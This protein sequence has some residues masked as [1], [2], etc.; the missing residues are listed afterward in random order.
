MADDPPKRPVPQP[1]KTLPERRQ[2]RFRDHD[3]A[4]FAVALKVVTPILGGSFFTAGDSIGY[5]RHDPI[6]VPTIRG[7][8]RFW[9]RALQPAWLSEAELR[10]RERDLWGGMGAGGTENASEPKASR[11]CVRVESVNPAEPPLDDSP[12]PMNGTGYALFPAREQKQG[13]Q[14]TRPVIPRLEPGI[15]FTLRI[16]CPHD[17]LQ[18]VRKAVQAWILFGGYGSRTRRGLGSLTVTADAALWLPSL[19]EDLKPILDGVGSTGQT[20]SLAGSALYVGTPI[21]AA[22]N[23]WDHAVGQLQ[24]FRQQRGFAREQGTQRP[25]RSRWPEPDKIRHLTG[26]TR[27]HMPRPEFKND[28]AWPRAAFGLPIVG[29]FNGAN[30]PGPFEITWQATGAAKPADRLASPLI[31]KALPLADGRFLPC[32][33]WLSRG[34]PDGMVVLTMNRTVVAKSPAP[35][36]KMRGNNDK[37]VHEALVDKA[38]VREAFL[39]WLV[40]GCNWKRVSG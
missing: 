28:P 21:A 26:Q 38:S 31:V 34:F 7:H 29:R 20:P 11:V 10:S 17:H 35:F 30:E 33:L 22:D 15:T 24:W 36:G 19:A 23:A 6:R 8:L 16:S 40:T 2:Q 32:A 39:G 3:D 25:G 27:G 12:P 1:P 18:E 14:V 37:D 5:R 4:T 9:W 13:G